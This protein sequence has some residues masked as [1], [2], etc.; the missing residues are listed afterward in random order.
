MGRKLKINSEHTLKGLTG[1][2]ETALPIMRQL[3]GQRG[4]MQMDLLTSWNSIVGEDMAKYSLPQKLVFPKD[5]HSD[6]CLTIMVPAGAFAMEIA[7]NEQRIVDKINSFFGYPA[8]KKIRILQNGTAQ[9]FI[10]EKKPID[11][12]KKTVVSD[13]EESYI[14]ELTRDIERP[15]LREAVENLGRLVFSQHKKQE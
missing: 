13:K 12:V 7:Q 10:K 1:V 8:V 9:D 14:T 3:L 6:G 11:K 4:F 2:S 5:S 15:E